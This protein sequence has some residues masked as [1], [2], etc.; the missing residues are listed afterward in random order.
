MAL[1]D[2]IKEIAKEIYR[3]EEKLHEIAAEVDKVHELAVKIDE[4]KTELHN[5]YMKL[6]GIAE[7]VGV[8]E[9]S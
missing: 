5:Y 9:K 8:T 1:R 4:V 2:E 3:R 7:K 6:D